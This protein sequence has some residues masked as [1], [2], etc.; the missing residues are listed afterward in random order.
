MPQSDEATLSEHFIRHGERITYF[1][2]V[3]D[4]VYLAEP[5]TRTYTLMRNIRE[6]DACLYACDHGEQILGRRED[7]VES[8]A[9]G[10]HPFLREFADKF[11]IPLLATLGGPETM[12]PDFVE[13][14]KDSDAMEAA[15]KAKLAP[16][17][18]PPHTSR[19]VDPNPHDGEIHA[20]RVQGNVYMLV[21]DGGNIAVQIGEQGPMVV[22]T[23]AGELA[24]NVIATI[25]GLTNS[26]SSIQISAPIRPAET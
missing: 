9:W 1:S 20:L 4:P 15:A 23:G 11:K 12:H 2:V 24:E 7:Q 16:A 8:Y 17:P 26:S 18:E 19:A 14:L 10:R 25:G 21:G 3:D 5:F 13:T 6:P 22:N